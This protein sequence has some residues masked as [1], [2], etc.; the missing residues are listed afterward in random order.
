[1]FETTSSTSAN[2][3]S[4]FY[5]RL[6]QFKASSKKRELSKTKFVAYLKISGDILSIE[7]ILIVYSKE[8]KGS[9]N[10]ISIYSNN[11][12]SLCFIFAYL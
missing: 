8:I 12:G 2:K 4:L 3:I 6:A 9:F 10:V 5:F 7:A 1:L 11:S